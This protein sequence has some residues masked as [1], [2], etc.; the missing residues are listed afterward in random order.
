[1]SRSLTPKNDERSAATSETRSVGI[2]DGAQ[3]GQRLVH[4]LAVEEGLAALHREAQARRL[5][6]LLEV[7]APA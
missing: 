2:V 6:R 1:M 5:Q 4:L 3:D 7:A